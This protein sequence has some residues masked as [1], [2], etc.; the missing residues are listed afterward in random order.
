VLLAEGLSNS[1]I[2]ARLYL[3]VGTV[4]DHVSAILAKLEVGGRVQ[5]ALVAERAG[6]LRRNGPH[7]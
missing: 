4:K 1:D 3:G 5:A 2:A 7:R 6:L